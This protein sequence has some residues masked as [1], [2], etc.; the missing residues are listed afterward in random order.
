MDLWL[1][2]IDVNF[3]TVF[4]VGGKDLPVKG[5]TKSWNVKNYKILDLPE[6]DLNFKEHWEVGF[7]DAVFCLEVFEY[8]YN[9]VQA[10]LN[11]NDLLDRG[12]MLYVTFPFVYPQHQ[13]IGQDCLRYTKFGAVKLL[14]V[15]GFKVLN[16]IPR[17]ATTGRVELKQFIHAEGMHAAKKVDHSEI[18]Y[19]V[20]AVKV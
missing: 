16:V 10:C 13:P 9:P 2:G 18:G 12:G 15:S 19:L 14:E 17:Y 6:C 8:I 4:D 1:A 20:T 3:D 5:R 11:L 7:A